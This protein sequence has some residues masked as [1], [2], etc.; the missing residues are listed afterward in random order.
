[1]LEILSSS[2]QSCKIV[3]AFTL[4]AQQ[5]FVCSSRLSHQLMWSR[6]V[7]TSGKKGHNIPCDLHME[8]L[9]RVL[10][11]SIK[12]L[13]ANKRRMLSFELESALINW[14]NF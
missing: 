9:N 3:E 12:C 4:L 6:F 2:I 14:M 1:M 11:D 8:H 7:N 10:K 5:K 13:G